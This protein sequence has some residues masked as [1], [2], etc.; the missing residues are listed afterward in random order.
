MAAQ[1]AR[2]LV[3]LHGGLE[4]AL[5]AAHGAFRQLAVGVVGGVER[6][7]QAWAVSPTLRTSCAR[8]LRLGEH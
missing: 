3:E 1:L 5:E 7:R 2:F 6:M 8:V 4:V